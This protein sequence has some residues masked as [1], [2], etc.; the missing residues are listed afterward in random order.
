METENLYLPAER[1]TRAALMT[2]SVRPDGDRGGAPGGALSDGSHYRTAAF[3]I[4]GSTCAGI[5][6]AVLTLLS[7]A[8]VGVALAE[9]GLALVAAVLIAACRL[10]RTRQGGRPRR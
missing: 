2:I 7:S 4:V 1:P 10:T 8:D 5:G 3:G 6:G 9:L